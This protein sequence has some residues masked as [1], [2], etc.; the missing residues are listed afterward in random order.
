M[1][2]W[3]LTDTRKIWEDALREYQER[4]LWEKGNKDLAGFCRQAVATAAQ[5]K[6]VEWWL[7]NFDVPML[8]PELIEKWKAFKA[9]LG[10]KDED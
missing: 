10:V 8:T 7:E 9:A 4:R 6:L 3:E 2:E 5:R 1:N